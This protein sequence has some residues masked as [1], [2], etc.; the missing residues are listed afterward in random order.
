MSKGLDEVCRRLEQQAKAA[1]ELADLLSE[2]VNAPVS[3]CEYCRRRPATEWERTS[4][5]LCHVCRDCAI[6]LHIAKLSN[7]VAALELRDR[8]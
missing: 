7:R 3:Y 2:I 1:K 5:E 6:D 4:G 8:G